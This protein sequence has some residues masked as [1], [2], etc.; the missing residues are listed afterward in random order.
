MLCQAGE[1]LQPLILL[2]SLDVTST[3]DFK[4]AILHDYYIF[5]LNLKRKI[6]NDQSMR[7]RHKRRV[8]LF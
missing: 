1:A 6:V 3:K 5:T 2:T 8:A 7:S 4:F